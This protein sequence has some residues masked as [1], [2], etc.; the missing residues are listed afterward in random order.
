MGLDMHAL[1]TAPS[2]LL[3]PQK[4]VNVYRCDCALLTTTVLKSYTGIYDGIYNIRIEHHRF[5]RLTLLR[6]HA[7]E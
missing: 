1:T 3:I 7:R 6:G 5:F 2:F 4:K